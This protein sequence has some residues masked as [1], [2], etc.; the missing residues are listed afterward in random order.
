MNGDIRTIIN[1]EKVHVKCRARYINTKPI[2]P[3]NK[4][5]FNES[6]LLAKSPK[7]RSTVSFDYKTCCLYCTN[8]VTER[9]LRERRAYSV[10]SKNRD[11]D[12]CVLKTCEQ[13]KDKLAV[14]V[15][16]QVTF[17]SDLHDSDAVYHV[18]CDSSFRTGKSVPKK[19]TENLSSLPSS[20]SR[21]PMN[22]DRERAFYQVMIHLH[23]NDEE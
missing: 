18:T 10:T 17:A 4:R 22:L 9:G 5:K 15:N 6:N 20:T 13:R 2:E 16:G 8:L 11:F 3:D 21:K 14:S 23:E 19:H 7:F 12:I 1:R